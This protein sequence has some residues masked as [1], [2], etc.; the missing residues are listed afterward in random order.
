M[1]KF[2]GSVLRCQVCGSEFKVP[3][4]RA[5]RA[6]TCSLECRAVQLSRDTV[7]RV[8]LQCENCGGGFDVPKC[9]VSRRRFCSHKC[10]EN[11]PAYQSEKSLRNSGDGNGMWKGGRVAHSDGYLYLHSPHHPFASN[12]YVFEHRLVMEGWLRD[13]Q[14]ESPFLVCL[15]DHLYLSPDFVVHH[16]DENKANNH[17]KNL[18]CMT[19]AEHR[20]HHSRS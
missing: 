3:P 10:R 16:R 14:P 2:R 12:G 8:T 6:K 9:H 1:A 4:S 18:E 11:S 7:R 17:I 5:H 20:R 15:G 19:P 13:N